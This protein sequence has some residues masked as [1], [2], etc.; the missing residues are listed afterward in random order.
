[1]NY[2]DMLK[3]SITNRYAIYERPRNGMRNILIDS[4]MPKMFLN[5]IQNPFNSIRYY[6]KAD[7]FPSSFKAISEFTAELA[8]VP[9]V[10]REE[11]VKMLGYNLKD[12]KTLLT[13]VKQKQ[14]KS[15]FIGYGGTNV[16]TLYWLKEL[17]R[18][19]NTYNLFKNIVVMEP[20]TLEPHNLLRFPMNLHK[21][22]IGETTYNN[23][24]LIWTKC[25]SVL[26][27][28]IYTNTTNEKH[29]NNKKYIRQLIDKAFFKIPINSYTFNRKFNH[30]HTNIGINKLEILKQDQSY[31]QLVSNNILT[32]NTYLKENHILS[33]K[34]DIPSRI[35]LTK[36]YKPMYARSFYG[37][38]RLD[39]KQV[40]FIY[41]AP[42]INT[43][44]LLNKSPIPLITA[45][46]GNDDISL[47]INPSQ[48]NTLQVESYGMIKLGIFFM[49]QLRLTIGL[50][51][52]LS[53]EEHLNH[54]SRELLNYSF[55][56]NV[57]KNKSA[58]NIQI[59]HSGTIGE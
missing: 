52:T 33:D 2:S 17:C 53:N 48:D 47:H 16:N 40:D 18:I 44:Q 35:P 9:L 4:F 31:K 28:N 32:S 49:N 42:D 36:L 11:L 56:Q 24:P 57:N 58:Y 20:D 25:K 8:G 46:H 27:D 19:T 39:S 38:F 34:S 14:L 29:I 6:T 22:T 55:T 30:F 41:G 26:Q 10:P 15:L 3:E 54:D 23:D 59:D 45:T 7:E 13:T 50:L 51:E 37:I 12:I 1:M 5:Y 43:R 21:E